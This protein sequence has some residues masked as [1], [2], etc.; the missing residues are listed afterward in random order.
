MAHYVAVS[1]ALTAHRGSGSGECL[2]GWAAVKPASF[3]M[4]EAMLILSRF[5]CLTIALWSFTE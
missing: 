5:P 4:N 1:G 3:N 2:G